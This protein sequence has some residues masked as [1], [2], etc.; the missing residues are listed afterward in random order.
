MHAV[1]WQSRCLLS[2]ADASGLTYSL[3]LIYSLRRISPSPSAHPA[4]PSTTTSQVS[5]P[6]LHVMSHAPALPLP[7]SRSRSSPCRVL[8]RFHSGFSR[9]EAGSLGLQ[10]Y[11][12]I[13]ANQSIHACPS[14]PSSLSG[15]SAQ[16]VVR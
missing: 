9:W 12:C 14:V 7:H 4:P 13:S 5:Q 16:V 3:N 11:F 6:I 10:G 2:Q 1:L 8:L 15:L